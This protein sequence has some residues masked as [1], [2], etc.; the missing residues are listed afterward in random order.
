MRTGRRARF[1]KLAFIEKIGSSLLNGSKEVETQL[2]DREKNN[3]VAANDI[4]DQEKLPETE[5]NGL[6][7]IKREL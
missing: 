1:R 7:E 6:L 4:T 2:Y 3:D 5:I